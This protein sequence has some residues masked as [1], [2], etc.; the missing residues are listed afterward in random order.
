MKITRLDLAPADSL[1]E[2]RKLW[3]DDILKSAPARDEAFRQLVND[4][5]PPLDSVESVLSEAF[6]GED[7]SLVGVIN[8][9]RQPVVVSDSIIFIGLNHYLGPDNAAYTGFPEYVRRLKT[10][11]RLPVDVV[12]E[13][14]YDR[15]KSTTAERPTLLTAMLFTGAV[16][17]TALKMLPE[18][19]S[20]ALVLGMADEE[21]RWCRDN[22]Q[23]I[24]QQLIEEKLLYSA[25]PDIINKLL[26]PAPAAT[27]IN[28]NAPG[29]T[30]QYIGLQIARAYERN[31]GLQAT[32][33]DEYVNNKQTLIR[34]KY[35]PGNATL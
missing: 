6:K 19:T 5:L 32:P 23:R 3:Y 34:S 12:E 20:E 29:N 25:D 11:R 8:P 10:L 7:I 26:R 15:Y 31:T 17:N 18:A 9:Y 30:V 2:L 35:A 21:Y 4:Q 16:H 28:L 22:E 13:F 27:L 33:T 24:W 14:I 1:T